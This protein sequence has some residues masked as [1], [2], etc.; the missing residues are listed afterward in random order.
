MKH[1]IV[2]LLIGGACIFGWTYTQH[3]TEWQEWKLQIQLDIAELMGKD[4]SSLQESLFFLRRDSLL[5]QYDVVEQEYEKAKTYLE[6][7]F[8]EVKE[9]LELEGKDDISIEEALVQFRE[10]IAEKKLLFEQRKVEIETEIT[11]VRQKYEDTKAA[12]KDLNNS[13]KKIREGTQE[14]IKAAGA[15]RDIVAE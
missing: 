11:E 10:K 1:V 6:G 3:P 7:E 8:G 13:A 2:A 4:V 14:G 15:I 12:L 9:D 5:E